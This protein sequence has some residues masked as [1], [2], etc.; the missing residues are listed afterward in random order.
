VNSSTQEKKK[1][2]MN[3]IE[4]KQKEITAQGEIKRAEEFQKADRTG[5]RVGR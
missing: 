3:A 4:E 1:K 5:L 2:R